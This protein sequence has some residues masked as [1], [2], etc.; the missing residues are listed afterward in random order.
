MPDKKE[1]ALLWYVL[2][3]FTYLGRCPTPDEYRRDYET[4][5]AIGEPANA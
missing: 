3:K 5:R 2:L 4:V 1:T